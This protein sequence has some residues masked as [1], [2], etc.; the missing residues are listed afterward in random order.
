MLEWYAKIREF[1]D[2]M[3]D[4]KNL[5]EWQARRPLEERSVNPEIT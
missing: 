2:L 5:L 4:Q 3:S 1:S